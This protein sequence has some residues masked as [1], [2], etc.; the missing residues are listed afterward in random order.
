MSSVDTQLHAALARAAAG[1]PHDELRRRVAAL[2][3]RYRA[4]QVDDATPGMSDALD[5][6][7]YAVFRMPATLRAL[8][9]A[10]SMAERHVSASFTTHL[11]LGGGTGAAAWAAS[12]LWPTIAIEIV[13]RQPAA[14]RLGQQLAA[15]NFPTTWHWTTTDLH[16]WSRANRRA[17][18][19][20]R[21]LGELVDVVTVGYVLG[22]LAPGDRHELIQGTARTA[23]TVV[24]VEPGTSGGHRRVLDVREVLIGHG[25][26]IAAPCPHQGPC[27]V[28]W[29]HF[30]ARLPRT[31][32]HRVLKDGTRNYEDEKFA[33][34][35]ATRLPVRPA[36]ARVLTRPTRRKGQ[37]ILDLC[38][39]TGAAERL[40]VPKSSPAYRAA[41]DAAWGDEVSR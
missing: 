38:T 1:V 41:R 40:V 36:A 35:V 27:P 3:H 16:T 17:P 32:L 37:V 11:D 4:E 23:S 6:L 9:A 33:Y 25:F 24:V 29:C 10:L 31:E 14:V 8:H 19:G 7:A 18:A 26:T 39:A 12:S 5:A 28:E 15:S 30:A 34:V 13:E 20:R 21:S 2:S 22:E